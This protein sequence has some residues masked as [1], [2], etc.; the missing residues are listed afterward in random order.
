MRLLLLIILFQISVAQAQEFSYRSTDSITFQQYN[1]LKFKDLIKTGKSAIKQE[2]DF[3]YLRMRLGIAYYER[4]NYD[5]ALPH[6][7]KAIAMNP[8]DALAQEYLYYCY[9]FSN[10]TEEANVY[11]STLSAEL[12][13]KI[14]Y[15]KKFT[16]LIAIGAGITANDNLSNLSNNKILNTGYT[17]ANA[18]YQG[19]MSFLNLYIQQNLANRLKLFYGGYIFN[20]TSSYV[21][22]NIF[23]N[24]KSPEFSNNQ[25]Q[26]NIGLSYKF[27][28]GWCLA[29]SFAYFIQ[30]ITQV[31]QNRNQFQPNNVSFNN[32]ATSLFISK[33]MKY[34]QPGLSLTLSNFL[35]EYQYQADASLVFYPWGNTNFYTTFGFATIKN[36]VSTQQIIYSQKIG[37]KIFSWLGY[38]AA[39]LAGNLQNYVTDLGYMTYNSAN[40]IKFVGN[41]EFHFY[42]KKLEIIPAYR[43]QLYDA[44]YTNKTNTN[45][46][47]TFPYTYSKS[48][49]TTTLKWNL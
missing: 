1:S 32:F 45:S 37:G 18:T 15:S 5:G 48:I 36:S 9:L 39:I 4:K 38:E 24:F 31:T 22:Q 40:P 26:L 10:R 27:K 11:A 42:I 14:K 35:S 2:I 23:R 44:E 7:Q 47:K 17:E 3:F 16:E 21:N 33:R 43:F 34:F 8:N 29:S 19:K 12:Q 13:Q 6:F 41:F 30:N 25:Y 28:K 20:T 46:E 49:L